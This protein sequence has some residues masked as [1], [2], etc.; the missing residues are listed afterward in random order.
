MSGLSGSCDG[1]PV[2]RKQLLDPGNRMH[3]DARENITEPGERLNG[4]ARPPHGKHYRFQWADQLGARESN[5]MVWERPQQRKHSGM[6]LLRS[7]RSRYSAM[8]LPLQTSAIESR[9]T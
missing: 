7:Y 6:G 8:R 1:L 2:V 9:P 5:F 3:C 4:I